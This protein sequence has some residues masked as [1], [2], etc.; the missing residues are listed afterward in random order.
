MLL[1]STA[2]NAHI[3]RQ[4][5]GVTIVPR[6]CIGSELLI[7]TDPDFRTASDELADW[8]RT[9]GI[10]T[11]VVSTDTIVLATDSVANQRIK[12][13][14]YIRDQYDQCAVRLSYVLLMGD[15]EHI[16]PWYRTVW[17]GSTSQVAAGTDLGYALLNLNDILPDLAIGRIS[18]D[19]AAEAFVVVR[20]TINYEKTPPASLDFYNDISMASYFQCCR[21]DVPQ[22][23]TTSRG[24]IETSEG[25]RNFLLNQGYNVERIYTTDDRY[26][27]DPTKAGYYT[28][29]KA[30]TR[31]Y[32][33]SFLPDDLRGPVTGFPWNGSKQD[34]IDAWNE[35]RFLFLHRNHGGK[36]GWSSPSFNTSD[37]SSLNNGGELP[38]VFSVNC[39]SGLFDN[40]TNGGTYN[41][42]VGSVY[43]A[44]QALRMSGGG[45]VGVL[46]DTRNSSTWANNAIT[47]GFFDA[48]WPNL[49]NG[50][51]SNTSI[52]RLADILNYGK[53]YMASQVGVANTTKPVASSNSN[54]NI[55]MWH[56]YGDP[57]LEL[58]TSRPRGLFLAGYEVL[59]ISTTQA[60]IG[61]G[62]EGATITAMQNGLPLGR[63]RVVNGRAD[64]TFI[65]QANPNVSIELAVNIFGSTT[66]A[67]APITVIPAQ[68]GPDL[69]PTA[70][71]VSQGMQNLDNDMPLVEDRRTIVRVYVRNS[72]FIFNA[73]Q[74]NVRAR[75]YGTRGGVSLSSSPIGASN[76][77]ITVHA[78]GGDRRDLDDSFWF[79]LPSSWRSGTVTLRAEIDYLDAISESFENNNEISE[80]VTF[81]DA[82][83]FNM[84]L[85]P[86]HIHPDGNR[87]NGTHIFWGTESYRWDIYNNM[88]RL[89]PS[90][91]LD[92]WRYEDSL[93]P[94]SH[95]STN[96]WD[97]RVSDDKTD[98]IERIWWWD[99]Q[100][101]DVAS[102]LHYMG[103]IEAAIDTDGTLGSAYTSGTDRQSWVKMWNIHDGYDD[104]Y[105]KGGN[106]MAHELAHNEARSHVNCAGNE[107]NPDANYPWPRPDC[108]IADVGDTGYFGLDVYYSK[109]GF[110]EPAVIDNDV[111]AFPLMGYSRPRWTSPY[112]WCA[113][114][115]RYGVTCNLTFD[116][117]GDTL[118]LSEGAAVTPDTSHG[119]IIDNAL[120]VVTVT[121]L[122]KATRDQGRFINVDLRNKA[123]IL[124]DTVD[125]WKMRPAPESTTYVREV[126]GSSGAILHSQAV[127]M[128][129]DSEEE[130]GALS[131][132]ELVPWASNAHGI[133]LRGPV[134]LLFGRVAS[135]N[136]PTVSVTQATFL[137]SAQNTIRLKWAGTDQ[138]P[139]TNLTYDVLYSRDGGESWWALA[140]GIAESEYL[141]NLDLT[142]LPSSTQ[143]S[144]RIQANDGFNTTLAGSTGPT[145]AIPGTPPEVTIHSPMDRSKLAAGK[146][147]ILDGTAEDNDD[148]QVTGTGLSWSSNVNGVLGNGEEV[149]IGP[150]IL[151]PGTHLITLT[152]MDSSGMKGSQTVE[153]FVD[154]TASQ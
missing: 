110:S 128:F 40:E 59:G 121:G 132:F 9:K 149:I 120:R 101:T 71:E 82:E 135:L 78:D 94:E 112:T 152:A 141:I 44:E 22:Q 99:S 151:S 77:P 129:N 31:Y 30:P 73:D 69:N 81:H 26:H 107:S 154:G 21:N 117:S 20:K 16:P 49:N 95:S 130:G 137:T 145:L 103:G 106:S 74:S 115:N 153:L 54:D 66:G 39:A 7:I 140:L 8:K 37:L 125:K 25:V 68:I 97:L 18:V 146:G 85:V 38:V 72:S 50:Y 5:V 11:R 102:E 124:T 58:W 90:A 134:P 52:T 3:L 45:A 88:Y 144:F 96:E 47:Q 114:L 46:G 75:L 48:I 138:D 35:G 65:T 15:A 60:V 139:N 93:K 51:G 53:L 10:T 104:W 62:V 24:F 131:F 87:S 27:D 2:I 118:S 1:T 109:W 150:D 64:M 76:N 127:T 136:A 33:T 86:L 34:I 17:F 80:T 126:R 133:L 122:V 108:H 83:T 98:M 70:I 148:G 113:L 105:L 41:T 123:D 92:M 12:I 36:G 55:V 61:Y 91:D 67:L 43:W 142:P 23:G 14:Q 63:A 147:L 79:Y 32:N 57:T 6:I 116:G 13:Q 19:T 29:F 89:H 42:T 143:G 100:T 111:D 28:G 119:T 56:A 84:V 4:F